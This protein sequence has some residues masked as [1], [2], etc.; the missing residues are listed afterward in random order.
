MSLRIT[1]NNIVQWRN[2]PVGTVERPSDVGYD[3]PW[4]FYADNAQ[5]AKGTPL[6][7]QTYREFRNALRRHFLRMEQKNER[8]NRWLRY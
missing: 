2:Q 5:W 6:S 7:R 1:R 4:T 8:G 3:A